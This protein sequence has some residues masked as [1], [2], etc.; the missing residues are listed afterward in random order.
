MACTHNQVLL[1]QKMIGPNKK[2][3]YTGPVAVMLLFASRKYPPNNL[4]TQYTTKNKAM[5]EVGGGSLP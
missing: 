5:A 3:W 4:K 2:Y 1:E